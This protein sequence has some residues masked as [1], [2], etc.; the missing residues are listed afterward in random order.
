MMDVMSHYAMSCT[1]PVEYGT[2]DGYIPITVSLGLSQYCE[3]DSVYF[4][5][6]PEILLQAGNYDDETIITLRRMNTEE[7]T[8][9]E[10][11]V[12]YVWDDDRMWIIGFIF[13]H[14][15]TINLPLTLFSEDSGRIWISITEYSSNGDMGSGGYVVLYYTKSENSISLFAEE[16]LPELNT[17][18]EFWIAEN[19]DGVDLSKLQEKYGMLSG[20]EYYGTGYM[21]AIDEEGQQVEPEHCV[22]YTVTSC[23]DYSDKEQYITR[24]Y[25]T[26]PNVEFYGISLRCSIAE[27]IKLIELQGFS[28]TE[29]RGDNFVKAQMDNIWIT[30]TA[31]CIMIGVEVTS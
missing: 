6:F 11:K 17:N 7:I 31:E 4:E 3:L 18:L 8:Q 15:E 14:T 25:I 9:P 29:M 21:P 1:I 10:Y 20:H 16:P 30:F 2:E 23:P 13:S 12:E 27:F 5:H 19:V 28:V 24:I 22:I 26:D